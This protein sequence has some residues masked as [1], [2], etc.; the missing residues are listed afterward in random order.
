M[1]KIDIVS[2]LQQHIL[3]L[4]DKESKNSSD[5]EDDNSDAQFGVG[6]VRRSE[7]TCVVMR[8]AERPTIR[9]AGMRRA[10]SVRYRGYSSS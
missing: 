4:G 2:Y 9:L 5:A 3:H 7:R 6:P 10:S 8:N 1:G